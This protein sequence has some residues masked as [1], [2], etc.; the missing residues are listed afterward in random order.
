MGLVEHYSEELELVKFNR[1]ELNKYLAFALT[2]EE[3]LSG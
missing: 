1:F 2:F 3:T